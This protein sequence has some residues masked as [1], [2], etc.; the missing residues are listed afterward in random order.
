MIGSESRWRQQHE[1]DV[2]VSFLSGKVG[3]QSLLD[4]KRCE[5]ERELCPVWAFFFVNV[6][7]DHWFIDCLTAAVAALQSCWGGTARGGRRDTMSPLQRLPTAPPAS[8]IESSPS[9][10]GRA[11]PTSSTLLRTTAPSTLC[12]SRTK[13]ANLQRAPTRWHEEECSFVLSFT[14]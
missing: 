5:S 2:S 4:K 7:A 14:F 13:P 1:V 9:P 6:K 11:A 12:S 8:S 3:H 10:A